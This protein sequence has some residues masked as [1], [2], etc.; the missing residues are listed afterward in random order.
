MKD[1]EV[2]WSIEIGVRVL[3][4]RRLCFVCDPSASPLKL[5]EYGLVID[6]NLHNALR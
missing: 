4:T 1:N 6:R 5:A 2:S 3:Q